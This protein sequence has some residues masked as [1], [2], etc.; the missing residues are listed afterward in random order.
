[1]VNIFKSLDDIMSEGRDKGYPPN[2]L[3][4][5]VKG[6]ILSSGSLGS[7]ERYERF[8]SIKFKP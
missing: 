1:M 4:I 2:K 6:S 8:V 5:K 7:V 3:V